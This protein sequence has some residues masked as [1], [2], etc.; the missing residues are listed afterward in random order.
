MCFNEKICSF[1]YGV[2]QDL[3]EHSPLCSVVWS[4]R[5]HVEDLYYQ[6]VCTSQHLSLVARVWTVYRGTDLVVSSIMRQCKGCV[7]AP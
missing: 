3:V 1:S 2:H 6:L 4:K 5:V 7:L